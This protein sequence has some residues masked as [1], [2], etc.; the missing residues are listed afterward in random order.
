MPK[1][2]HLHSPKIGPILFPKQERQPYWLQSRQVGSH[3]WHSISEFSKYPIGQLHIGGL[4]L[5]VE[6]ILHRLAVPSQVLH[7]WEHS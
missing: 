1:V 3:A 7:L 2:S 5:I 6:Q 4:T